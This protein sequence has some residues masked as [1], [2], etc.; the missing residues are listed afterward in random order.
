V[1]ITLLVLAGAAWGQSRIPP[2]PGPN[3]QLQSDP[4]DLKPS[5]GD[6]R[7]LPLKDLREQSEKA[8]EDQAGKLMHELQPVKPKRT[9]SR[10]KKPGTGR[11]SSGDDQDR[12]DQKTESDWWP[13]KPQPAPSS[14]SPLGVSLRQD[15]EKDSTLEE[16]D[17]EEKGM[18]SES[19]PQELKKLIKS[20]ISP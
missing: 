17:P 8:L 13:P 2:P 7:D 6:Q 19:L 9:V 11:T 5:P 16:D 20:Q 12:F 3:K 10:N 14:L 4:G 1:T 18:E 15:L